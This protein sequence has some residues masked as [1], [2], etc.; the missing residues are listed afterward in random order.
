M[1]TNLPPANLAR[2][3]LVMSSVSSEILTKCCE[4]QLN[5]NTLLVSEQAEIQPV[6]VTRQSIMKDT[7]VHGAYSPA[8]KDSWL[9]LVK[10]TFSVIDL[11][12][13]VLQ[14]FF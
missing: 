6:T 10:L 11:D 14:I 8:A 12:R 5:T 1:H 4:E 9:K 7:G 3:H 13:F 2:L